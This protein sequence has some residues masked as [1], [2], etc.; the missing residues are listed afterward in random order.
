M[1]LIDSLLLKFKLKLTPWLFHRFSLSLQRKC[2]WKSW[3]WE[4][5]H[6]DAEVI[7]FRGKSSSVNLTLCNSLL[8][9]SEIKCNWTTIALLVAQIINSAWKWWILWK[10]T[11]RYM[12]VDFRVKN[13]P[14]Y[15]ISYLQFTNNHHKLYHYRIVHSNCF[16]SSNLA[17]AVMHVRYYTVKR[18]LW[19]ISVIHFPHSGCSLVNSLNS[20]PSCNHNKTQTV[21]REQALY[22][23]NR[24]VILQWCLSLQNRCSRSEIVTTNSWRGMTA[25][26]ATFQWVN[27]KWGLAHT[28]LGKTKVNIS[29][30]LSCERATPAECF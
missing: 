13:S 28:S 9:C 8:Y 10:R 6:A 24:R 22:A 21:Y 25:A 30:L 5:I 1:H 4:I 11:I 20:F 12:P 27:G 15:S 14:P 29:F 19:V 17:N 18:T 7:V 16:T 3:T 23:D 26:S 2:S